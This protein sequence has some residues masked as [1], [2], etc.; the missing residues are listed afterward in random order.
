[1]TSGN[2]PSITKAVILAGGLGM[3]L[4]PLTNIIP[5]PL[6]PIGESTVLEIQI[7]ALKKHGVQEVFIAANYMSDY[8]DSVVGDGKKYGIKATVSQETEPL[9]TCGPLT[10]LQDRLDEPFF[11]VN[12]DILTNLN[13][14]KLGAFALE[15][16]AAL[17][18]V[19][20]EI[21]IPFRFGR[22]LVNGDYITGIEEKPNFLH[23]ILAGIYVLTPAVFEYIPRGKY[24]GIDLLIKDMLARKTPVAK[25]L[26][27]DYWID[28]GQLED[29]ETAKQDVQSNAIRI[30]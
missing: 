18:V 12:G 16:R 5:K 20:K 22:V 17:T 21:A 24:Y 25:Y 11:M 4:R 13:F 8:L 28:I 3:R 6:L 1:M 23:E 27:K 10:L 29:Y 9:G 15:K 14:T 2:S 30:T 26:T 19:T 7:L